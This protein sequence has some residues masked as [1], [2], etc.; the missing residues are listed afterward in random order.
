MNRWSVRILGLVLL[1]VFA[2]VMTMMYRQLVQLQREQQ[3]APA[4]PR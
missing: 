4:S 1:L 3:S 2:L